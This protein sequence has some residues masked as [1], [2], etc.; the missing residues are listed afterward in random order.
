MRINIYSQEIMLHDSPGPE[1]V[2]KEGTNQKGEPET[3]Y[4]IRFWLYSA[5]QLHFDAMDDD[6]SAVTFWLPK[7]AENRAAMAELFHVAENLI[8][9]MAI[10]Q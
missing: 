10:H 7:G 1:L 4:G 8:F 9:E 2:T 5:P 3:F 6:R